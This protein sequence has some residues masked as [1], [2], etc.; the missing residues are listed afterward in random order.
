[1]TAAGKPEGVD[2]LLARPLAAATHWIVRRPG[3]VL[4]V[5]VI[6]AVVS[7]IYSAGW[8]GFRTSRLDLLNP[9]SA[10][11]KLWIEYIEE[12]GDQDDAVVAI[13]GPSPETIAP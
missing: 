11:N 4:A 3:P 7:L 2:S 10:F 5:S 9:D 6:A 1:M 12:F 13:E 8:L